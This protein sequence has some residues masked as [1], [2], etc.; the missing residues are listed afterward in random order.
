VRSV[1]G[2]EVGSAEKML[3]AVALLKSA[4][5]IDVAFVRDGAS[6]TLSIE[7]R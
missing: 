6:K 2:F 7:I 4:P 3:E 1:N 5:S